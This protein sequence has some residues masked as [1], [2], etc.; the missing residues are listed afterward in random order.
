MPS[1]KGIS[2][3][4][5]GGSNKY[6][7]PNNP[8]LQIYIYIYIYIYFLN[9]NYSVFQFLFFQSFSFQYLPWILSSQGMSHLVQLRGM[10]MPGNNTI[11][12]L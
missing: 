3:L 10:C 12:T 4:I 7:R 6:L 11:Q 5:L 8:T 9:Y 2:S 1:S